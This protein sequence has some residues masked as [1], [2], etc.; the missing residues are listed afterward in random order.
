MS[1][2]FARANR[3]LFRSNTHEVIVYVRGKCES[4]LQLDAELLFGNIRF[5]FRSF[6]SSVK[7][8]IMAIKPADMIRI[9]QQ[10]LYDL[11]RVFSTAD[12]REIQLRIKQLMRE[13]RADALQENGDLEAAERVRKIIPEDEVKIGKNIPGRTP[14]S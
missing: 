7:G 13:A 4:I 1:A 10:Y 9:R 11:D 5:R 8:E 14:G 2:A 6:G 12:P 3:N